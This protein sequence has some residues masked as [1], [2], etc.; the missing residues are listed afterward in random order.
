[1]QAAG[2]LDQRVFSYQG[3]AG[4]WF[5]VPVKSGIG[6]NSSAAP[7]IVTSLSTVI[8]QV[9]PNSS[10]RTALIFSGGSTSSGSPD[11]VDI[12]AFGSVTGCPGSSQISDIF[13][14]SESLTSNKTVFLAGM[15]APP[16]TALFPA[17]PANYKACTFYVQSTNLGGTSPTLN[18]YVQNYEGSLTIY[19]DR[20]SF[21]QFTTGTSYQASTIL[22]ETASNPAAPTNGTLAAGSTKPGLF[23]NIAIKYVLG[24]TSPSYVVNVIAYCH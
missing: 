10:A 5:S 11:T 1:M 19:D 9:S 6:F 3:N 2:T 4:S 23:D 16:V 17:N 15:V 20:I 12:F 14:D 18:V 8:L 21:N 7:Y 22:T 13:I 24:G